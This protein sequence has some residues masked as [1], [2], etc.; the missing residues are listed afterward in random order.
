MKEETRKKILGLDTKQ[1][2]FDY[3]VSFLVTQ[4]TPSKARDEC[5]Y[6][7]PGELRCA[8]GCLILPEEYDP[9][10][11]SNTGSLSAITGSIARLQPFRDL[12]TRLQALHDFPLHWNQDGMSTEGFE[13]IK[14][15]A[16]EHSLILCN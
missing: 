1:K 7:G 10:W 14:R 8:V 16:S 4:G 3:V 9:A 11:D 5:L 15:I 12:L 6:Y 2:V 13:K